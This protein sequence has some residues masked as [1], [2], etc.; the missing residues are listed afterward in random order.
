MVWIVFWGACASVWGRESLLLN[1]E[2]SFRLGDLPG[3]ESVDFDDSQWETVGLPHS[4]SIPYFQSKDFYVGPGWYR[5]EIKLSPEQCR[6]MVC[7][8]FDGVFQETEVFVNGKR[9]GSH[10]GGYT[11]FR[12]DITPQIHPGTNVIAI[13]VNNEWKPDV[14]PRAGEHVFSG[15]IYRNVRLVILNKAH[16]AWYGTWVTTPDLARSQGSESCVRVR[17][18]LVNQR[19][20][21]VRLLVKT[22]ISD[23]KGNSIAEVK[24]KIELPPGKTRELDQSSEPIPQPTLWTPEHPYLYTVVS[25]VFEEGKLV[26]RLETPF[27]FRW[28]EWTAD[29]GFFLNGKHVYLIGANVHQDHAG[30]G[31]AVTE[32]GVRRDLKLMK[33]AGFNWIRGSHYPH[34]PAFSR[35]CD[36]LGL[37]L[38]SE[39]CFWGTGP[40]DSPW[41]G[42][43]YPPEPQYAKAFDASVK[44]TLRDMIRIHRNHPSIV[45]WSLSNEAFFSHPST[46]DSVRRLLKECVELAHQLDPDRPT[47]IGGCQRAQLDH[48]GDIAAYNGDG[49]RLF[50]NPGIP[51]VV[52]EYGSTIAERPG[53]YAP[54]WGN[55]PEGAGQDKKL[56]YPWRYPW[57][58]GEAIWCG[59]DH[60]SL[61]GKFGSMGLV[62]YFRIPKRQWYWY[63]NEYAGI[64]PP[65]FPNPGTPA[66]LVLT[67]DRK[68]PIGTDGTDDVHLTVTVVDAAG[69]PVS[70]NVPV[71]LAV[72]SGPGEFPTGKSITFTPPSAQEASDIAIR[73]GVAGIELR[74]YYAG[75]TVVQA[76]SPGLTSAVLTLE[77]QGNSPYVA[78]TSRETSHR[79]YVRFV[80]GRQMGNVTV[81]RAKLGPTNASSEQTGHPARLVNDGKLETWWSPADDAKK[82]AWVQIDLERLV[83]VREVVVNS[84]TGDACPSFYVEMTMDGKNWKRIP[85]K[86]QQGRFRLERR[87]TGRFV[88]IVFG[89]GPFNPPLQVRE[90]EVYGDL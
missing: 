77:F 11:G 36:E 16:I 89:N 47:A 9:T 51:S 80:Q 12:I 61:G 40:F 65:S 5:K 1:R 41:G 70:N 85:G 63:R 62:D 48:L 44:Q 7:L 8:D 6:Q 55:L 10:V 19:E 20:S 76:S 24:S 46:L 50:M 13:R 56:K 72:V 78:G 29:R 68:G 49:A 17:T 81:N 75:K 82:P 21:L 54:G 57:R 88:R 84:G 14:A 33:E 58:S 22:S 42:S 34:S 37:M 59:F 53:D 3:A 83:A 25:E 74:S 2:W 27:G 64:A 18:E 79:P 52:S 90:I 35:A 66:G 26:D 4:F 28:F 23:P 39:N 32:A 87:G 67:P 45:A 30:W 15:G 43:A 38:M 60:G 73:D 69:N 71:S 86:I 31:D